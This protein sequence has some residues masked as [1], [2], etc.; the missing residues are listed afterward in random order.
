VRLDDV[1]SFLFQQDRV[2]VER[3]LWRDDELGT[4]PSG[5]RSDYLFGVHQN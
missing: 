4:N 5:L 1:G 2:E 3:S